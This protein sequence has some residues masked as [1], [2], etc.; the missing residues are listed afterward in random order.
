MRND[1]LG[2]EE[3]DL[4]PE[5]DAS[6]LKGSVRGK[7]LERYRAGTHAPRVAGARCPCAVSDRRVRQPG[8]TVAHSRPNSGLSRRCI[9]PGLL[10]GSLGHESTETTRGLI[11]RLRRKTEISSSVS[12]S[13]EECRSSQRA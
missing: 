2:P 3:D 13:L 9:G 6:V 8:A 5:Y 4:R 1:D 7:Y 11:G 10:S 12:L